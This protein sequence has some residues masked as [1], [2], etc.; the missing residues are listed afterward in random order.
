MART[1]LE[2]YRGIISILIDDH[3][4]SRMSLI[5][6]KFSDIQF[7]GDKMSSHLS[8]F[9]MLICR[10]V[11]YLRSQSN[12]DSTS[13]TASVDTLD[14]FSSTSRWWMMTRE[15]PGFI[16][17]PPSYD[18]R[19]SIREA[20]TV[21]FS[22]PTLSRIDSA[23]ERIHSFLSEHDICERGNC[24]RLRDEILSSWALLSAFSCHGH[25]RSVTEEADFEIAYDTMRILL[26]YTPTDDFLSLGALRQVCRSPVLPRIASVTLSPGFER[27]LESSRAAVLESTKTPTVRGRSL[28]SIRMVLTN[29]FRLLVQLRSAM[30]GIDRVEADEY[31]S[32]MAEAMSVLESAGIKTE[33]FGD[34]RLVEQCLVRLPRESS[35]VER[36]DLLGQRIESLVAESQ[37]RE[38]LLH[39]PRLVPRLVSLI[40]FLAIGTTDAGRIG[41]TDIKRALVLLGNMFRQYNAQAGG[42]HIN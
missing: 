3:V 16:I 39:N 38:F 20:S 9:M 12:A 28:R 11:S 42:L 15:Q 37:G 36:L 2:V 24:E 40:L 4:T 5:T 41:D 22:G 19:E 13:L 14:Y 17:R 18:P 1:P 23:A 35:T 30:A 25:G 10:L 32:M 29:S 27:K 26:F 21:R 34:D 33:M 31:E 6:D 8:R 7:A